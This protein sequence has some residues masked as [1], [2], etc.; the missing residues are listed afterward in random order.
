MNELH[1]KIK[2]IADKEGWSVDITDNGD[3]CYTFTFQKFSPYGRDFYFD[4]DLEDNRCDYQVVN[5]SDGEL[6][7]PYYNRKYGKNKVVEE[8]DTR[9]AKEF[10]KLQGNGMIIYKY[11]R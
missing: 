4:V 6:Y 11:E 1:E 9:I 8:L 3:D 5:T 10:K 7:A 2:N